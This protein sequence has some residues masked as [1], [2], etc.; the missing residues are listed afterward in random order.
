MG[1]FPAT[2]RTVMV[3][4]MAR[5]IPKMKEQMM[6]EEAVGKSTCLM[7][8]QW[9]APKAREA[10]LKVLGTAD[11]ASADTLT[12]VGRAISPRRIEA[13]RAQR[14]VGMSKIS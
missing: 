1:A 9:V 12:M 2:I 11:N 10:S 7:V 3:S 6:P 13:F 14:P 8:C 5:P 4:P